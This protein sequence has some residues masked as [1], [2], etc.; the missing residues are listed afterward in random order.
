M[1]SDFQIGDKVRLK[2]IV[3]YNQSVPIE[4]ICG[5]IEDHNDQ[6]FMVRHEDGHVYCLRYSEI[7]H[8]S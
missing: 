5:V 4:M 2:E 1:V 3:T 7:V 8:D 6:G